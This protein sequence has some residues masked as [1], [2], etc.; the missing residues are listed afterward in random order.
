MSDANEKMIQEM[1]ES[2]VKVAAPEAVVLFGSYA[3]G[4][5]RSGSDMDFLVIESASFGPGRDRRKEMTRLWHALER[6]PVSKD[7]L[8]YSRSEVESWRKSRNHVI[9]RALR[10]GR[11]LYGRP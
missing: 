7:I 9:S 6:F 4:T 1:A 10:E 5:A 8:L 11:T 3:N 2:I